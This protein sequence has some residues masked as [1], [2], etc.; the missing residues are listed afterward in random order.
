VW[1]VGGS[2]SGLVKSKTKKI[3]TLV[4]VHL[5]QGWLAQCKFKMTECGIM[6][7]C[8]MVLRVVVLENPA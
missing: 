4:S 3:A 7:I 2:N 8:D 6:F 5:E 1:K